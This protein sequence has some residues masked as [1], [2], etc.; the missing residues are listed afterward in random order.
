MEVEYEE[1]LKELEYIEEDN[2][3]FVHFSIQTAEDMIDGDL[4]MMEKQWWKTM[5]KLTKEEIQ[6]L[7]DFFEEQIA[8]HR[9]G[10][11]ENSATI[12]VIPKE[13][14]NFVEENYGNDLAI[15]EMPYIVPNRFIYATVDLHE[16][17]MLV[18]E[19]AVIEYGEGRIY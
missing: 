19:N 18:N 12:I 8:V 4:G 15:K 1:G 11:L 6:N 9:H 10:G 17:R 3:I 7:N 2:N 16:K 13:I 14:E 5:L